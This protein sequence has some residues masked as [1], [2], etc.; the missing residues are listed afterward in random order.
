MVTG[1]FSAVKLQFKY[2]HAFHICGFFKCWEYARS[3]DLHCFFHLLAMVKASFCP[4]STPTF[5]TGNG[6]H[7][8]NKKGSC[9]A[10]EIVV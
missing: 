10:K 3:Q 4:T 6:G 7:T 1:L 8:P 9:M 5:M 2:L